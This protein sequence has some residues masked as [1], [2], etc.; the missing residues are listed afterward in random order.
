M[1]TNMHRNYRQEQQRE[2]RSNAESVKPLSGTLMTLIPTNMLSFMLA[3]IF[4]G[5]LSACGSVPSKPAPG[6]DAA[7][8][9]PVV[10][11]V[12][13]ALTETDVLGFDTA[14]SVSEEEIVK[15]AGP[16]GKVQVKRGAPVM[17]IQAGAAAPDEIMLREAGNFFALTSFSGFAQRRHDAGES[18]N[19]ARALRLTAAKGGSDFLIVYWPI[20]EAGG[21]KPGAPDWRPI[22]GDIPFEAEQVRMRMRMLVVDVKSGHWATASP[23]TLEDKAARGGWF[24]KPTSAQRIAAIKERAYKHAL[25]EALRVVL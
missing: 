7:V 25:Q 24:R 21:S 9:K 22:G 4:A 6:D 19:L 5:V 23:E 10:A 11:V 3:V 1:M 16:R 17:L 13:A 8:A 2:M 14:Q 18:A 15:A 20:L 12:Q